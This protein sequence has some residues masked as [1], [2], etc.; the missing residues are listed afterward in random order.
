MFFIVF[1][2]SVDL[3]PLLPPLLGCCGER[4]GNEP[5]AISS[6]VKGNPSK[7]NNIPDEK[8]KYA[9]LMGRKTFHPIFIN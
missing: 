9:K 7:V 3:F 5:N 6:E 8:T 4:S 1:I 2:Q